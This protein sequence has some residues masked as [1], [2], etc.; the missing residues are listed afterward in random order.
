MRITRKHLEAKVSIV[1][2]MIGHDDPQYNERGALVLSGAYG[3][4][5]ILPEGW[6]IFLGL[7]WDVHQYVGEAGGVNSLI[8]YHAPAKEASQFLSGMIAALR[9]AQ[10]AK[11]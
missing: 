11:V 3:C 6:E 9:I 1:N 4:L 5:E 7:G 8:G 2:G 10:E